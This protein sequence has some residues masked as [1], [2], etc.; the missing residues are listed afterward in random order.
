[1]GIMKQVYKGANREPT[2]IYFPDAVIGNYGLSNELHSMGAA[3]QYIPQFDPAYTFLGS[4]TDHGYLVSNWGYSGNRLAQG[5]YYLHKNSNAYYF[6]VD[7]TGRS[8][9]FYDPNH[10]GNW[11]ILLG[12][13]GCFPSLV[14]S[15]GSMRSIVFYQIQAGGYN[16]YFIIETLTVTM[17]SATR[18]D[19]LNFWAEAEGQPSDPYADGGV[20]ETGG[21]EGDFDGTSDA[22]AIPA[23]PT[24]SAV[25]TG[26]VTLY[27][28]T[29]A[30]VQSL[31]SYMWSGLFDLATLRKL[32]ADPMDAII[33]FS[34]VP[35]AVPDGSTREVTVGNIPTGINMTLAA[36]QFVE[37]DCGTLNVNEYWGAY[38]DY[39][40]YTKAQIYLPFIGFQTLNV[41]DIMGK[42]VSVKY[43]VD[44]FSGACVAYVKCGDAVLYSYAGQCACQIPI[45][46]N[47]W[48][49]MISA[50]LSLAASIGATVAS[51]G[52]SAP[53]TMAGAAETAG[54]VSG[55]ASSAN[56]IKPGIQRSGAM[57]GTSGFLAVMTPYIVLTRP[58]QALPDK[59][60]QI[61]GYPSLVTKTL[62][63]L[64]GFTMIEDIH[65]SGIEATTGEI[66][67]ILQ[68]LK[69]GVIF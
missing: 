5:T 28:P 38:L 47:D 69:T 37:V 35:V 22:I 64:E 27:N 24:M 44:I 51:G 58:R 40:P 23:L 3:V 8:L 59:Q 49:Q 43:H 6:T 26:F 42:A 10:A 57:A 50:A 9:N 48:T 31:A 62:G 7:S 11:S 55:W 56:Q 15:G 66:A 45:S 20:S 36:Q 60:D 17:S 61:I 65:L 29:L 16:K 4:S 54:L 46:S 41:D 25:D 32:F 14:A 30:E 68:L 33:G 67:E 53:V 12:Y 34:I 13:P 19:Y 63:D 1:M 39:E 2:L 21:G 18:A 52:L